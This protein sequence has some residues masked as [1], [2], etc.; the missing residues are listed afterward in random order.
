MYGDQFGE[1]TCGYSG[2]TGFN[3]HL[4]VYQMVSCSVILLLSVLLEFVN[5]SFV[6]CQ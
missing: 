6:R 5:K 4:L 3:G 1:F 2:L